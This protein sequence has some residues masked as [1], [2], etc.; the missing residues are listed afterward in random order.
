MDAMDIA[1]QA[2]AARRL[3][4]ETAAATD[5]A[6]NLYHRAQEWPR[7]GAGWPAT[8]AERAAEALLVARGDDNDRW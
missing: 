5:K 3:V 6:A 4:R 1:L 7:C 2:Q 8:K